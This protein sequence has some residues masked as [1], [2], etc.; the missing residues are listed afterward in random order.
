[1]ATCV[2]RRAS[3]GRERKPQFREEK[4][5]ISLP[6]IHCSLPTSLAP[7]AA[8]T[9]S[10]SRF[11]IREWVTWPIWLLEKVSSLMAG[12]FRPAACTPSDEPRSPGRKKERKEKKEKKNGS[13]KS[14]SDKGKMGFQTKQRGK[15]RRD[16]HRS[17]SLAPDPIPTV[18]F[19]GHVAAQV[20]AWARD[21]GAGAGAACGLWI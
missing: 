3:G 7:G 21:S 14:S 18:P 8:R 17:C 11:E 2:H 19:R 13:E 16:P 9:K 20:R 1:M 10:C 5:T 4:N 12:S 6:R 15:N